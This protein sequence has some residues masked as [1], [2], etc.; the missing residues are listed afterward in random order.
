MGWASRHIEDL[1]AGRVVK[2]R[3][4]GNSMVPLIHSGDLVTIEPIANDVEPQ[5]GDI[6][7]CRVK[8][9]QYLHLVTA[10][11]PGQFQISNNKGHVNGWCARTAVFGIVTEVTR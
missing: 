3:P 9:Q 11:K 6:V 4:K 2:C 8:G 10:V 5:K 1:Q 7:L